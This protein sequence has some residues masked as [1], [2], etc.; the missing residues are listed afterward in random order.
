LGSAHSGQ[1]STVLNSPQQHPTD[2]TPEKR[3]NLLGT[4]IALLFTLDN[5]LVS[6]VKTTVLKNSAGYRQI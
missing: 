6:V 1:N 5:C 3:V 2:S 4:D